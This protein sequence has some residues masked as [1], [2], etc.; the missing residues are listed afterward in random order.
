MKYHK[1]NLLFTLLVCSFLTS[2]LS[3]SSDKDEL[4]EIFKKV[5]IAYKAHREKR[6]SD[7]SKKEEDALANAQFELCIGCIETRSLTEEVNK[8]L[9]KLSKQEEKKDPSKRSLEIV[10]GLEA[11]FHYTMK[12]SGIGQ[13][14]TS[15][16]SK[17]LDGFINSEFGKFNETQSQVVFSK[18]VDIGRIEALHLRNGPK[19]TYYY[20]AKPPHR[21]IVVRV[22][23]HGDEQARI[24]YYKMEMTELLQDEIRAENEHIRIAAEI[25]AENKDK[26]NSIESWGAFSDSVR[27]E[28]E[29]DE[30]YVDFGV[31]FSLEH[32][33]NLPRK[34]TLLKGSSVTPVSDNVFFKSSAE[35]ST[36][37]VGANFSLAGKGGDD[38]VRLKMKTNEAELSIPT[39]IDI[40]SSDVFLEAELSATTNNEQRLRFNLAGEKDR[41]TSLEFQNSKDGGNVALERNYQI[42]EKQ[43]FSVKLGADTEGQSSGFLRYTLTF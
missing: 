41:R 10:E 27:D 34:I 23:V 37:K 32:K 6:K 24:T 30:D 17:G 16:C 38:Y 15:D 18:N 13:G 7:N 31:G 40:F 5:R 12:P 21:D 19:K 33:N 11:M 29:T 9:F 42:D 35:V 20:R 8:V 4:K 22:D 1:K 43:S 2:V 28:D 26:K 25:A 39:T 3:Y 14:Q 36:K